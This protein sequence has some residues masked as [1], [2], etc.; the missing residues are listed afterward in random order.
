M[1]SGRVRAQPHEENTV[2]KAIF[3][4]LTKQLETR[5]IAQVVGNRARGVTKTSAAR[6]ANEKNLVKKM[7]RL[8]AEA[9]KIGL[10]NPYT[11]EFA[12]S[13]VGNKE[14][15]SMLQTTQADV[16]RKRV[17]GDIGEYANLILSDRM[18]F[19]QAKITVSDTAVNDA[20]RRVQQ[21]RQDNRLKSTD[22]TA[23]ERDVITRGLP[24]VYADQDKL[25]NAI[26]SDLNPKGTEPGEAI[27]LMRAQVRNPERIASP[28]FGGERIPTITATGS[29]KDLT[30]RRNLL[31]AIQGSDVSKNAMVSAILIENIMVMGP[32]ALQQWATQEQTALDAFFGGFSYNLTPGNVAMVMDALN[33]HNGMPPWRTTRKYYA[34]AEA[35]HD[36]SE[37]TP[38]MVPWKINSA[39]FVDPGNQIQE[40]DNYIFMYVNGQHP[41]TMPKLTSTSEKKFAT[42]LAGTPTRKTSPLYDEKTEMRKGLFMKPHAGVKPKLRE[43]RPKKK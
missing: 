16:R 37:K 7:T 4:G 36:S 21:H 2:I 13:I 17:S 27:E 40:N 1:C 15:T 14:L 22:V 34:S 29:G 5:S 23:E 8:Q 3:K 39:Y 43:I 18:T 6:T 25:L 30:L 42:Y 35:I 24:S 31:T 10:T 33:K 28:N 26:A 41:T 38:E 20:A 11:E 9:E 12:K 19:K 32:T